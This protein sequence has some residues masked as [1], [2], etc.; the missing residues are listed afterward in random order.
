MENIRKTLHE[1]LDDI[2]DINKNIKLYKS[3]NVNSGYIK[4]AHK[5]DQCQRK[6][7]FLKVLNRIA[8]ILILPLLISTLSLIYFITK[9]DTPPTLYTEVKAAPGSII[10]TEL[11]DR[12]T[13]WLNSGST[14]RYPNQFADDMRIVELTGEGF[15]S[16]QS[17]PECPFEVS[18][19]SGLQIIARGTTFNINAYDDEP[20]NEIVLQ[21]GR[22][23]VKYKDKI[24]T[25]DPDEIITF[26]KSDH[27][28]TKTDVNA[29]D[30]I[31][32]KNGRLIFRN[33]PLDEVMRKLARRYNVNITLHNP[34]NANYRIRATITNETIT[35]ILDFL[36]MAAPIEWE[37][38]EVEQNKDA[39]LTRQHIDVII[40]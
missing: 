34:K 9:K 10:Q 35:Q 12:S 15:F 14:L 21:Q 18:I 22:I 32:W 2:K 38:S 5:I 1:Q 24:I 29:N 11:P 16:I 36:K 31:A 23:D 7:S 39:T 4:T 33:T 40:K 27:S 25:M 6:H 13:V 26:H 19:P 8:A 30:K 37:L 28:I 3:I 20:Q 17:N